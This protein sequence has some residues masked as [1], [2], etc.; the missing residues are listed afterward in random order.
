MG[1]LGTDLETDFEPNLNR[2][3]TESEPIANRRRADLEPNSVLEEWKV[4]F[5]KRRRLNS[6]SHA[7]CWKAPFR[8]SQDCCEKPCISGE[9]APRQCAKAQSNRLE[10]CLHGTRPK[11]RTELLDPIALRNGSQH[12]LIQGHFILF[13]AKGGFQPYQ[14]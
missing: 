3:R 11:C 1:F 7:E 5:F 9:L 12:F 4:Q 2:I 13:C 10:F 14:R 6:P 8:T